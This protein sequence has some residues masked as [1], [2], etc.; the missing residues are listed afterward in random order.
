[1]IDPRR[2]LI[3]QADALLQTAD[4]RNG[5]V[6]SPCM[7]ICR[8]EASTGLCEGCLRTLGEIAGWADLDTPDRLDIWRR[9]ARRAQSTDPGSPG[10]VE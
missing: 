1:M 6:R 7:S 9:I 3:A 4:I 8:M 2:A 5:P 10:A